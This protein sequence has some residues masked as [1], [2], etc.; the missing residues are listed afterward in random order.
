MECDHLADEALMQGLRVVECWIIVH[1]SGL[2]QGRSCGASGRCQDRRSHTTAA[3]YCHCHWE[4]EV[5]Q[6]HFDAKH[7]IRADLFDEVKVKW[8]SIDY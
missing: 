7:I 4:S 6:D 2:S 3:I 5:A 1:W 8:N